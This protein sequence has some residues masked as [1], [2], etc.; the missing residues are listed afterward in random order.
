MYVTMS[1][2]GLR[3]NGRR[4]QSAKKL[5]RH[6]HNSKQNNTDEIY[7]HLRVAKRVEEMAAMWAELTSTLARCAAATPAL[8][9]LEKFACVDLPAG[10]GGGAPASALK[11]GS[12]A[13]DSSWRE[14]TPLF[15]LLLLLLLF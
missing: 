8:R 1:F 10:G 12:A 4:G 6:L 11:P 13:G 7:P 5:L 15:L 2:V 3:R 9:P 14:V